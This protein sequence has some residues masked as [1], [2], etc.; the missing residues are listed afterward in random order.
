MLWEGSAIL[1]RAAGDI[2]PHEAHL[3]LDLGKRNSQ[4]VALGL[5]NSKNNVKTTVAEAE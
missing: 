5:L 1:E 3:Y 2:L 4:E